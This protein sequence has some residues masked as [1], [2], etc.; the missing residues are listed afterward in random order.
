MK[1]KSANTLFLLFFVF[2][3]IYIKEILFLFYNSTYSPDYF[4]Y[5]DYIDYFFGYRESTGRDQGILYYYL[6]SQ[7]LYFF[8][9]VIS[10]NNL[11]IYI[12]RTIQDINLYLHLIGSLGVFKLLKFFNA[13]NISIYT[14]LIFLNFFPLSISLRVTYKPEI[15]AFALL[16]WIIYCFEVYKSEKNIKFIYYSIPLL[17]ASL[18]S[19]GSVLGM[20]GLFIFI[21]YFKLI[22]SFKKKNILIIFTLFISLFSLVTIEDLRSNNVS[23]I[24]PTHEEKYNNTAEVKNIYKINFE[25]IIKSPIRDQHAGSMPALTLLDIHGD[26]FN[27]YWDNDATSLHKNRKEIFLFDESK[28]IT[29][30]T[31][32]NGALTIYF[33]N[34]TDVYFREFLGLLVSVIYFLFLFYYFIFRKNDSRFV[35]TPIY[36]I[37]ILLVMTIGGFPVPNWDPLVGDTIKPFYYSFFIF[38]SVA[39][40]MSKYLINKYKAIIFLIVYI[41]LAMYLIGFPKS[42][43]EDQLLYE[44]N[45][46]SYFCEINPYFFNGL[47]EFDRD[48]CDLKSIEID[49]VPRDVEGFKNPP[50]FKLFNS[51]LFLFSTF[52]IFNLQ[53]IRLKAKI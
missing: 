28:N 49:Y 17:V 37:F 6:H 20:V 19:K 51:L 44:T 46:Y 15:L 26:Y 12:S 31:F 2:S 21:T 32:N 45:Q 13:K 30:P 29:P 52:S 18:T 5:G 47:D 42:E 33:Q 23:L 39:F 1:F 40:L 36:G 22:F 48:F 24:N 3:S 27:L 7:Y 14:T 41:P 35:L 43:V 8:K 10:E 50:Q 38:I 34:N 4:K 16:P 9:N 53:R 25:K 11:P